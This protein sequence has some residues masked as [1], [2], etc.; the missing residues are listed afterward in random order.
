ME[1]FTA[2]EGIWNLSNT[3]LQRLTV[4]HKKL[5]TGHEGSVRHCHRALVVEVVLSSGDCGEGEHR[6]GL[7]SSSVV[8]RGDTV[9]IWGKDIICYHSGGNRKGKD[10]LAE[11]NL[12]NL[13]CIVDFARSFCW[14]ISQDCNQESC[15][16]W[17][18]WSKRY[19]F[20][21]RTQRP[22]CLPHRHKSV[23]RHCQLGRICWPA[24]S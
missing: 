24:P 20:L 6:G 13:K 4:C 15:E 19:S 8:C 14:L 17:T 22:A 23:P 16:S 12:G 5:S 21:S 10:N 7:L 1:K 2:D 18:H 11:V 3:K 9:R